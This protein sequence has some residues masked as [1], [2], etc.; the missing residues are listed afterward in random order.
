ML[1]PLN[2]DN[3]SALLRDDVADDPMW[4]TQARRQLGSKQELMEEGALADGLNA[5]FWTQAY[6]EA[7]VHHKD[8]DEIG[9]EDEGHQWYV[10]FRVSHSQDLKPR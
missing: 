7:R 5:L 8:E 4:I 9:D 2:A 10:Y 1:R 6:L 3:I